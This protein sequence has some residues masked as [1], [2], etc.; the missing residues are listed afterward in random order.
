M[1]ITRE[2][3]AKDFCHK[4][5]APSK[6]KNGQEHNLWALVA[7]QAAEGGPNGAKFNP[8]NTTQREPG[9]TSFNH[10]GVQEYLSLKSGL[11][12]TA[13]TIEQIDLHLNYGPILAAMRADATAL[14]T[15]EALKKSS[16]GTGSG[17]L[18]IL[19]DV[20]RFWDRDYAH[21][22]IPQ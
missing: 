19:H 4:I 11:E 21:V 22:L 17:A 20:K 16:W 5:G 6:G 3:W 2:Q 8:L 13:T 10:V 9:S 1:A 18:K 15:L 14:E 12:A 7:W